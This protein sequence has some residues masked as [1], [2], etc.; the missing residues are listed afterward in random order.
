MR[1]LKS[2]AMAAAVLAIGVSAFAGEGSNTK[3]DSSTQECLDYMAQKM[4]DSGW[5]GIEME[6]VE[7]GSG[8]S[9]TKVVPGSPAE[10]GGM[11]PGDVL[12]A[13]YGIELNEANQEKIKQARAEWKPGQHVEYTVRRAGENHEIHL[14]LAAMPADVLAS[15][16]GRHLMESHASVAEASDT[17]AKEK[18]ADS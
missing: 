2:L 5:V 10:A 16:I 12:F 14:T 13:M 9:I 18:G 3:C 8:W 15:W 7:E 11:Q 1:Y 4:K 17:A 6:Q